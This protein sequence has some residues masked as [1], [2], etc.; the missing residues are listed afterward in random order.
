MAQATAP[1]PDSTP[2]ARGVAVA[3]LGALCF[4][5]A[6]G[7]PADSHFERRIGSQGIAVV[8]VGITRGD[9]ERP[10][11]DHLGQPMPDPLGCPRILDA[12]RQTLGQAQPPLNLRQH[13]HAG[14]RGQATAVE[15]GANGAIVV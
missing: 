14:I 11:P 2:S 4:L 3:G 13:Q 12:A 8:G 15:V 1:V 9:H 5:A 7:Q 6:L 10:K